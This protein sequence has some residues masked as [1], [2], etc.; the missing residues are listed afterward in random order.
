MDISVLMILKA[1]ELEE[2]RNEE[3]K[4]TALGTTRLRLP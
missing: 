1:T 3:A 2:L 4:N